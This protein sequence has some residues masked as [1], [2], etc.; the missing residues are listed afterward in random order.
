MEE[1]R[2]CCQPLPTGPYWRPG[3]LCRGPPAAAL[4]LQHQLQAFAVAVHHPGQQ[5]RCHS[6]QF[7]VRMAPFSAGS[8]QI[9]L[10]LY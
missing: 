8:D 10:S 5:V 2:T 7:A 9:F 4:L 1:M 6:R 3:G